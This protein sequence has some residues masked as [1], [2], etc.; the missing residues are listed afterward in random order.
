MHYYINLKNYCV[1]NKRSISAQFFVLL[2]TYN[3]DNISKANLILT[4][5]NNKIKSDYLKNYI[6]QH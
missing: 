3:K 1:H 4:I 2:H 6:I 5:P